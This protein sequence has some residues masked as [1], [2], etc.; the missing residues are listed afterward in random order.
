MIHMIWA[1][2]KKQVIGKD[3]RIPWHIKE[4]LL[5]YKSKTEGQTVL[6][7]EATYHSLKGYY[8]T[9]PLPY[10]KIYVAS[11]DPRF[12][13]SDGLVVRD[14]ISFI[15]E[16][17]E[18]LWVVGGASIYKLCLPYADRLYISWIKKDYEGDMY[19]PALDLTKFH[20][21][22]ENESDLVHYTMYER[23]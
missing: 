11:L 18:D 4:D 9:K 22:W 3:N 15:K 14:V 1:M 20:L 13:I 23:V 16:F 17:K 10:G 6:M 19:F 2:T 8:K 5:Y 12:V 21:A 7:G